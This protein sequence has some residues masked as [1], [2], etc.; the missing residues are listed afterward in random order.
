MAT[1]KK[2]SD[3]YKPTRNFEPTQPNPT[4]KKGRTIKPDCVIRAFSIVMGLSWL[5]AFDML[6]ANARKNYTIPN[7]AD[8]YRE[9]FRERGY[10]EITE[11]AVKG[12][13]RLTVEMFAELHPT[14]RY[15]IETANHVTTVIN[16]VIKDSW[17]TSNR[18][19]Y[20]Y[21]EIC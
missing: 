9:I 6:V 10:K 16:G 5:E 7:D 18:I 2:R 12:Q 17:N 1:F 14:G 3:Y 19:I 11:K 21:F 20:R 15:F 4:E 8:N 13:K